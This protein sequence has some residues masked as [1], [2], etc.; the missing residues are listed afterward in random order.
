MFPVLT[1]FPEESIVKLVPPHDKVVEETEFTVKAPEFV[2]PQDF[3]FIL[4][5][6]AD[7]SPVKFTVVFIIPETH[8]RT[9]SEV[10]EKLP[11]S[12]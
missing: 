3:E 9:P 10:I 11:E 8:V 2:R 5:E 1:A 6:F 4:Y 12:D 7:T